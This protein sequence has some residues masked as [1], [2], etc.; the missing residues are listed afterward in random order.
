MNKLLKQIKDN[1]LLL[2]CIVSLILWYSDTNNRL[3]T[4]EAKQKDQSSLLSKIDILNTNVFL[5]C[6]TNNVKCKDVD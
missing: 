2:T 5:L 3:T 1:W 6:I 4:V